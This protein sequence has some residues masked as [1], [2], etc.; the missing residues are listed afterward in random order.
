M[1]TSAQITNPYPGLRPFDEAYAPFF[2]GRD[3]QVEELYQKLNDNKFVAVL[4]Y[5]GSGKSSLVKCGIIPK[6]S[7]D[8]SRKWKVVSCRPGSS[9]MLNLSSALT[10]AET[11]LFAPF[12]GMEDF[13]H[14]LLFRS[15]KGLSEA[16]AYSQLE[17]D[18]HLLILIDQFEEL[19]R[20]RKQ[21]ADDHNGDVTAMQFA[22]LLVN[23]VANQNDRIHIIITMRSEF[24]GDCANFLGLPDAI[25]QG[26]YLIPPMSRDELKK[27]IIEP[28]TMLN[29]LNGS[30]ASLSRA[31][32]ERVLNDLGTD[33]DQLPILQHT[34]RRTWQQWSEQ[35]KEGLV[36]LTHYD[37]AGGMQNALNNHANYVYGLLDEPWKQ[38]LCQKLF[39]AITEKDTDGIETRRP[40]RLSYLSE[41]VGMD[42]TSILEVVKI[43]E[44]NGSFLQ[45]YEHKIAENKDDLVVDISH[46]SLMRKWDQLT[47]WVLDEAEA[48][49]FYHKLA[50]NAKEKLADEGDL[51]T[52]N[53]LNQAVNWWSALKPNEHWAKRYDDC[54]KNFIRFPGVEAFLKVSEKLERRRVEDERRKRKKAARAKQILFAIVFLAAVFFCGLS[55]YAWYQKSQV[56]V[57]EIQ[58]KEKNEDLLTEKEKY[59]S[60]SVELASALET[61]T[62]RDATLKVTY[63]K[64]EVAFLELFEDSIVL[65]NKEV[66]LRNTLQEL[67]QAYDTLYA[68]S[69]ELA[70]TNHAL[71]EVNGSLRLSRDRIDS[72]RKIE[73]ARS[74]SLASLHYLELGE[75]EEA[76]A[77]AVMG[78]TLNTGRFSDENYQALE[79]IW[80]EQADMHRTAYYSSGV[81]AFSVQD[82]LIVSADVNGVIRMQTLKTSIENAFVG[83]VVQTLKHRSFD[84]QIV[85]VEISDDGGKLYFV[86]QLGNVFTSILQ[87]NGYTKLTKVTL[88]EAGV[89]EVDPDKGIVYTASK[90]GLYRSSILNLAKEDLVGTLDN[91]PPQVLK[92]SKEWVVVGTQKGVYLFNKDS[93][94]RK[95]YNIDLS[96]GISALHVVPGRLLLLGFN[97]GRVAGYNLTE[98]NDLQGSEVLIDKHV[99]AISELDAMI[100]GSEKIQLAVAGYDRKASLFDL[101]GSLTENMPKKSL[102]GHKGWIYEIQYLSGGAFVATASEDNTIHFWP[103]ETSQA[104]A[105]L[106]QIT[107]Y[108]NW[109]DDN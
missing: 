14:S 45:T 59:R 70:Q 36:G 24:L 4:G 85:D 88:P 13:I 51:L 40:E 23:A 65:A 62:E 28:V 33:Q 86:T 11:N 47:G 55:A 103:A 91:T 29:K 54:Y 17:E 97:N 58:L 1:K 92:E 43:F 108:K 20:F 12:E 102:N 18:E 90:S 61:V 93:G 41:V 101:D 107:S 30:N 84:D 26:Q 81:R 6:L 79:A 5:S 19:F 80:N 75:G 8:P 105:A 96:E 25:N 3:Q 106:R 87:S 78:D 22:N 74:A 57:K 94:L 48:A 38:Q 63:S 77:M 68:D 21:E 53:S 95:D 99:S 64:L 9:P 72:L 67:N 32:I 66:Q 31:L 7:T 76:L 60:K 16:A 10:D 27:V 104:R 69:I 34:L 37:D 42:P 109:K 15:G 82:S 39:R 89:R 71:D 73:K 52:K 56:E 2:F 49:A 50:T 83:A 35:Q 98:R 46:E 100:L 44:E